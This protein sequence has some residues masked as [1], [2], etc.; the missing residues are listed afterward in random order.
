MGCLSLSYPHFRIPTCR[1][2][3]HLLHGVFCRDGSRADSLAGLRERYW[4]STEPRSEAP[5][6]VL[7]IAEP[8]LPVFILPPLW[9]VML[10]QV[11]VPTEMI[12]L[13]EGVV[14][15]PAAAKTVTKPRDKRV[16]V[17]LRAH[18]M[19][20]E[21]CHGLVFLQ[22]RHELSVGP[23]LITDVAE[24]LQDWPSNKTGC[25]PFSGSLIDRHGPFPWIE[26]RDYAHTAKHA[27]ACVVLATGVEA[28]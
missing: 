9:A 11:T 10:F 20:E 4:W 25:R 7:R 28:Y 14:L 2:K 19:S 24:P 1:L 3:N 26:S 27:D 8:L 16:L 23:H 12:G 15:K 13:N 18:R 5:A 22:A 21:T 17:G 6:P